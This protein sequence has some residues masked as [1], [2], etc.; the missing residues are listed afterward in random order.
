MIS[1][2]AQNIGA[3]MDNWDIGLLIA[4]LMFADDI[5]LIAEKAPHLQTL[6]DIL[7]Q[8]CVKHNMTVNMRKTKWYTTGTLYPTQTRRCSFI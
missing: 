2:D 8:F 3:K 7:H 5:A 4:L 1:E 6:L